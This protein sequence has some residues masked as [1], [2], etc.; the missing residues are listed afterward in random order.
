MDIGNHIYQ[1]R[2][3]RYN[4][5]NH[6]HELTF[7]CYHRK[8]FLKNQSVCNYLAEAI[9]FAQQKYAIDLWA[10]VFMPEHVHLLIWPRQR[11][12]SISAILQTIKQSVSKKMASIIKAV[13]GNA[14]SSFHFWQPGGG[15]DRNVYDC[16]TARKIIEYI[17][18]NPIRKKL[19]QYPSEW[20]YSSYKDWMELGQGPIEI[21]KAGF[22][23]SSQG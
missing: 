20:T 8:P 14:S 9:V 15:F 18:L 6:A 1:K 13:E 11:E 2:C 21:Q 23:G 7:S 19:A 3:K 10:Y 4:L 5:V 17:H 16:D 12:Y 22:F